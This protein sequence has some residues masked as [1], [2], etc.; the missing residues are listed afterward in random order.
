MEINNDELV[1][2]LRALHWHVDRLANTDE[3]VRNETELTS[4]KFL[5]SKFINELKR[6]SFIN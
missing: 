5:R 4:S 2:V 1:V 3:N 6:R